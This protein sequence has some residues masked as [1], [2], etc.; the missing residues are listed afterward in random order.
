MSGSPDV[1]VVGA[2]IVGA[3]CAH[4][5]AAA[6]LSVAVLDRGA[7]AGGTTGAGEGNILL[8]DKEPGPELD[9]GLLSN[10]LWRALDIGP[11]EL[12]AKGGL[13]VAA[14]GAGMSIVDKLTAGQR[15]AG[16]EAVRVTDLTAYEPRL[17]PD[18]V[19]GAYYPQDLQVQP[20][21]ATVRL[22]RGLTVHYGRTVTGIET[23]GGRV[24]AVRTPTGAVVNAAGVWAGDVAALAGVR[25]PIAPRRGFVLVTEPLPALVR[26]KVYAADYLADVASGDAGLQTS[27][28]VESTPAGTMLIGAS[29]E[30]VGFD[31]TFSLP[32]L[33]RLAA[34]AVALFPFLAT[35]SLLRAYRG[36]RPY[37]PD[38]LPVIGADPRVAG[39]LHACGHEG[40]GIG[41]APATGHLIAQVLT[42]RPPDVDLTPFRPERFA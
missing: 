25:L 10:R 40:A 7:P 11:I 3:A 4:Y 37:S 14:T 41:L 17:A 2:G 33:R 26:H 15:A 29:R 23:A 12:E 32:A 21:L 42:G 31:R 8:S 28:V 39:L 9:L 19:G 1:V 22:L 34:Q 6:G 27:A 13:T 35:V 16:V 38:H 5:A 36:F 18:L 30:R 24:V 20:M